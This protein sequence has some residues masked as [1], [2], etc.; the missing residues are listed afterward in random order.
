MY[1]FFLLP[2]FNPN[3]LKTHDYWVV[4][5]S[6]Y[7]D[8]HFEFPYGNIPNVSD[9]TTYENNTGVNIDNIIKMTEDLMNEINHDNIELTIFF[10]DHPVKTQK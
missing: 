7:D 4:N 8:T 5:D 10:N 6:K 3:M 9:F 1:H 2:F